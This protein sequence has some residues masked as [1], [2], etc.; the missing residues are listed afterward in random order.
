MVPP[1]YQEFANPGMLPITPFWP[2][3]M[4]FQGHGRQFNLTRRE[5]GAA[6]RE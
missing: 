3:M 5:F 4:R 2:E 1:D 6:L